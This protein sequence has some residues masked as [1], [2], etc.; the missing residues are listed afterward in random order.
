MIE[1]KNLLVATLIFKGAPIRILSTGTLAHPAPRAKHAGHD[2]DNDEQALPREGAVD[3]AVRS[4]TGAAFHWQFSK[5]IYFIFSSDFFPTH[6]FFSE[7]RSLGA[8]IHLF[9]RYPLPDFLGS[10]V[11]KILV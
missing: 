2:S 4:L 11:E 6:R 1:S 3:P 7:P 5:N 10:P 8:E 9:R